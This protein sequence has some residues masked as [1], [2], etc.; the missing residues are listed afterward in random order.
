M[1]GAP[2]KRAGR[3]EGHGFP[4][5]PSSA[6]RG[7][8]RT[9]RPRVVAVEGPSAAGKSSV[10]ARVAAAEDWLPLAEATDRLGATVDLRYRSAAELARLERRLLDEEALRWA[11]ARTWVRRGRT[12]VA[13][14]GFLGP[15]TYTWGLVEAG[16]TPA[17]TLGPLLRRA[18]SL[19]DRH[20]WGL[21]DLTIYLA[22][23]EGTRRRRA[24]ADPARHPADLYARHEVVAR[25]ER[26]FYLT[27]WPR[28]DPGRVRPVRA[29]APVAAVARRVARVA[30]RLPR[31]ASPD[32]RL[33]RLLA[34]LA[35]PAVPERPRR[36]GSAAAT[37]KKTT[38]RPL[39]PRR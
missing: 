38:G 36:R 32:A 2:Q 7:G 4:P 9:A 14:T 22:V 19:A 17:R 20:L 30:R 11:T 26:E 5:A 8:G 23:G 15:L 1:R 29:D 27:E 25:R 6:G 21:A 31:R 33:E 39:D 13:D 24:R 28:V 10:V 35:R 3:R 12:V 34:A 37:V 16:L 18:R